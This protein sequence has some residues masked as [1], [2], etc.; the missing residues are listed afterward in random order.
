MA[1]TSLIRFY[2]DRTHIV[3]IHIDGFLV[4]RDIIKWLTT[5][6]GDT[7]HMSTVYRIYARN[8]YKNKMSV[9]VD[10]QCKTKV[11]W[12]YDIIQINNNKDIVVKVRDYLTSEK[13]SGTP[14][15]L[16]RDFF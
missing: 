4:G 9:C 7:F 14:Q 5:H 1:N 15:Q 16:Y 10:P 6:G 8:L 13:I 3:S 12:R 2:F 11:R